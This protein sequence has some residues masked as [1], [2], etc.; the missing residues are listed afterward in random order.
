MPHIRAGSSTMF[1]APRGR[2]LV[3]NFGESAAGLRGSRPFA[4]FE[5]VALRIAQRE[6]CIAG[7]PVHG[8]E[9]GARHGMYMP[10]FT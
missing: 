8:D 2:D 7:A 4:H 9:G 1:L 3:E 10:P 5:R 6:A